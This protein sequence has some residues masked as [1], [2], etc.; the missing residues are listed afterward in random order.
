MPATMTIIDA[1]GHV[2]E[3]PTLWDEYLEAKYRAHG[4]RIN[5][6]E[7]GMEYLEYDGKP[8]E[9]MRHGVLHTLGAMGRAIDELKPSTER[10]YLNSAPFGSMN[11]RER[12]E[13]NA[14]EGIDRAILYPTIGLLWEAEVTDP[15]LTMAH[16]RAY[17]KELRG[18]LAAMPG[19]AQAKVAG[20]NA[21][22]AY[23]LG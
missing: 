6:D 2:L 20:E 17:M 22:R 18:M 13:L 9:L 4:I 15:E 11:A 16:S 5:R 1:D 23:G 21:A 10:T 8:A 12:L 3:P 14:R 19:S 7:R